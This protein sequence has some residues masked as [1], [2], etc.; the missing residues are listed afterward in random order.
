MVYSVADV[1]WSDAELP[2]GWVDPWVGLDRVRRNGPMDNSGPMLAR[3]TP[4]AAA[5]PA[6][7]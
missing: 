7:R 1:V 5:L 2:M 6:G 4:I 3:A